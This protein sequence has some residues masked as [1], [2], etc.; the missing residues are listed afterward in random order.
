MNKLIFENPPIN[1]V[2]VSTYF[3]PPLSGLRNEHIGLFWSEIQ[4]EFNEVNQ[5]TP[6][7]PER[8]IIPEEPFPMPRYWFISDDEIYLIQIQRSAFIFN[9]RRRDKEY[10]H[11]HSSIKPKF[12]KYFGFFSEFLR[13]MNIATN[14]TVDVCELS[15]INAINECEYWSKPHDTTDVIPSFKVIDPGIE[16]SSSPGFSSDFVF[17]L[18]TDLQLNIGIRAGVQSDVPTLILE[19]RARGTLGQVTKPRTDEWFDRAHDTIEKCFLNMTAS[20]IQNQYWKPVEDQ[21]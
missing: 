12:D 2:I 17:D 1:E 3:N 10:P 4:D 19:I 11:F 21:V 7:H 18:T 14:P 9:W 20:H 16:I 6:I 5:R 15:Y 8:N 13:R